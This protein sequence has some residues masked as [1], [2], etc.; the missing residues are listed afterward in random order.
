MLVEPVLTRGGGKLGHLELAVVMRG[1]AL[2]RAWQYAV[3]P[4]DA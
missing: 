3:R 1:H 4:R 2:Y